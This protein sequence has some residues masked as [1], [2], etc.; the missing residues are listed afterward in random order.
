MNDVDPPWT[1]SFKRD[2]VALRLNGSGGFGTR[3]ESPGNSL[4]RHSP[5]EYRS[6]IA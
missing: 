1:V 4:G 2:N 3:F 5:E 6:A